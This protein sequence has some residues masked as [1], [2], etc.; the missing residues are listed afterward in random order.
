MSGAATIPLEELQQRIRDRLLNRGGQGIKAL[1]NAFRIFDDNGNK[2]LDKYEFSKALTDLGI[3]VNKTEFNELMRH[4]DKNNDGNISI[5]EFVVAIRTNMN[6]RRTA[7][8]VQAFKKLDKE[9]VVSDNLVC[10]FSA[11]IQNS[12]NVQ[13]YRISS[14]SLSDRLF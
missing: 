11:I 14:L 8:V 1:S 7:L 5:D 3:S 12:P 9:K 2:M 10:F 4:F 13:L 6:S